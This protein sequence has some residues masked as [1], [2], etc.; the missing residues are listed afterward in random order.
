VAPDAPDVDLH[1][2][3]LH[4]SRQPEA[5]REFWRGAICVDFQGTPVKALNATDQLLHVCV[6]GLQR[7][8]QENL[9]WI[10][11]AI[12][13]LRYEAEPIDW[14][15][16]LEE[17]ER[18]RL[19]LQ[20]RHCLRYLGARF[21]APIP[22]A[23][24]TRLRGAPVSWVERMEFRARLRPEPPKALA[25]AILAHQEE[26]RRGGE[27]SSRA[28]WRSLPRYLWGAERWWQMPAWAALDR[29][30]LDLRQRTT[31]SRAVFEVAPEPAGADVPPIYDFG[32]RIVFRREGNGLAALRSGWSYA[33]SV[34]IWS[35][36]VVA[37]LA[38]LLREIPEGPLRLEIE[39]AAFMVGESRPLDVHVLI[40]SSRLARWRLTAPLAAPAVYEVPLPARMLVSSRPCTIDFR[41]LRPRS[42]ASLGLSGD[43]RLLG[44]HLSALRFVP[45]ALRQGARSS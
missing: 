41:I 15:R 10:V 37:R 7:E 22:S 27:G 3:A 42:P 29:L 2:H 36:G 34:G 24:L 32:Q 9:R 33:E 35:E 21:A 5:D 14:Q 25:Q 23:V 40:D 6:H 1:W 31:W 38:F 17:V 8:P 12:T 11:D 45:G 13:I 19:V 20:A 43:Q 26:A 30:G 16:L 4:E 28:F 18:R 44:I 39:L